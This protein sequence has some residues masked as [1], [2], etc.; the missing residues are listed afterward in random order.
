M[1][2]VFIVYALTQ[3]RYPNRSD[4]NA[5]GI[6]RLQNLTRFAGDAG[7]GPPA[8]AEED[9][10]VT[11]HASARCWPRQRSPACRSEQ[12]ERPNR[13]WQRC[14][15]AGRGFC[16]FS[17]SARHGAPGL[18]QTTALCPVPGTA[19]TPRRRRS[20]IPETRSPEIHSPGA[21]THRNPM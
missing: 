10:T 5:I 3:P 6:P 18:G 13:D 17:S 16:R 7:G 9:L 2:T 21:A 20:E 4:E 19:K 11:Q 15:C 14:G 1:S 12:R 8:P